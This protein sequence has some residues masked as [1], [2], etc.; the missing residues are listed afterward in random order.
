M[1]RWA[2]GRCVDGLPAIAAAGL[3]ILDSVADGMW[4]V[5]CCANLHR[6][7]NLQLPGVIKTPSV[8]LCSAGLAASMLGDRSQLQKYA[9][10]TAGVQARSAFCLVTMLPEGGPAGI[11]SLAAGAAASAGTE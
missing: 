11:P 8:S 3:R 10:V 6:H 1:V 9:D 2:E 4:L 7:T 5:G